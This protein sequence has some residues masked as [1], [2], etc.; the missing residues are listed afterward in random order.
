MPAK[1]FIEIS[2]GKGLGGDGLWI[3]IAVMGIGSQRQKTQVSGLFYGFGYFPLLI[4]AQFADSSRGDFPSI[5]NKTI[6]SERILVVKEEIP[7]K[8]GAVLGSVPFFK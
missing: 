3:S 5:G 2:D 6:E 7:I 1:A 8:F 4:E